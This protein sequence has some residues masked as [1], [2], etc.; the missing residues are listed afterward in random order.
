[1]DLCGHDLIKFFLGGTEILSVHRKGTLVNDYIHTSTLKL[2][3]LRLLKLCSDYV[4][5]LYTTGK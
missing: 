4:L 5:F 2:V 3:N 1:M